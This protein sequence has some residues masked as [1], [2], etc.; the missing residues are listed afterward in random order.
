[1]EMMSSRSK[2]LRWTAASLLLL[3]GV[4][5]AGLAHAAAP[6]ASSV[7][8]GAAASLDATANNACGNAVANADAGGKAYLSNMAKTMQNAVTRPGSLNNESCIKSVF[9]NMKSMYSQLNSE[10]GGGFSGLGSFA[11]SLL[12]RVGSSA[13]QAGCQ[14]LYSQWNQTS[15]GIDS[16]TNLPSTV[17]QTA[18][19]EASG[20]TSSAVTSTGNAVGNPVSSAGTTAQTTTN[21]TSNSVFNNLNSLF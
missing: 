4:S 11:S 15:S 5:A 9:D 21:S 2:R 20:V 6:S 3:G 8:N 12:N 7:Y 17:G 1:M 19:T 18:A 16:I 13:S 14:V 10:L